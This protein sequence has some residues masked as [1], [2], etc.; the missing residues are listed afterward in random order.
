MYLKLGV[1]SESFANSKAAGGGGGGAT[2]TIDA[3]NGQT[4]TQEG[5]LYNTNGPSGF[6]GTGENYSVTFQ[7]PVGTIVRATLRNCKLDTWYQRGIELNVPFGG[8]FIDP[9][10]LSNWGGNKIY[11][12]QPN[13]TLSFAPDG[14]LLRSPTWILE[15]TTNEGVI[16]FTSDSV[17]RPDGQWEIQVEFV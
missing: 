2:W 11:G 15:S 13:Q 8:P 6:Y 10:P 16:T 4:L 14:A 17:V 5:T 7:G 3:V 9:R 12:D 1:M